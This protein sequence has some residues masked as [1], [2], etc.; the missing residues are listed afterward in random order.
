MYGLNSGREKL[1]IRG[2][3]S[4]QKEM[5]LNGVIYKALINH[6]IDKNEFGKAKTEL[7]LWK[8]IDG[9]N[10]EIDIY[11]K[12]LQNIKNDRK[13]EL[14]LQALEAQGLASSP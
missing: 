11:E 10:P 2:L 8:K 3:R 12:N 7:A 5:P 6:F 13:K 9:S 14:N 4:I 1:G